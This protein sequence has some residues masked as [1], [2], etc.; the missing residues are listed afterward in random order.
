MVRTLLTPQQ[1][2]ISI[3]VPQNYIG[4]QIEVLVYAVD[5]LTTQE[6]TPTPNNAA[7]YKGIFSKEEGKKFNEYLQ[8]ARSE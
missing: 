1:Q 8:Q 4:R 2:N 6:K 7:R 5:E 3:Q